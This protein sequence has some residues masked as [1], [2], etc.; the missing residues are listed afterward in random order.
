MI[1]LASL[2][3]ALLVVSAP[4]LATA[5]EA[6]PRERILIDEGWRF[7]LGDPADAPPG[8]RYDVRPEVK[9]SADGKA[10]DARPEEAEK[11]VAGKAPVL[12]PWI[13]PTGNAFIKDPAKRHVRPAGQ[14]RRRGL[15]RPG[16]V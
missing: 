6:G 4:V 8:L 9:Q 14:S 13:L 7:T 1:R 2:C 15:L 11:L 5:A 12:K 16:P 3:L 10:A